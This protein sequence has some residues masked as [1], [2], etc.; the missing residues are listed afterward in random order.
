METNFVPLLADLFFH[1]YD[2]DFI[3]D[4]VRK[5]EYH[6]ARSFNLSFRCIDDALPLNNPSFGDFTHR[7]Y[8][9]KLEIKD[10]TD[11]VKSASY[12]DLLL[13]IDGKGQL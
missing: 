7:T 1:S 6:L 11:S 9:K 10:A 3:A 13:D 12:L 8:P 4:L 5:K 2:A